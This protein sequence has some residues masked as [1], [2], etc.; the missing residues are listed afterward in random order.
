MPSPRRPAE[1]EYYATML[2]SRGLATNGQK[3]ERAIVDLNGKDLPETFVVLRELGGHVL[4]LDPHSLTLA[5][6]DP[7][8]FNLAESIA[9]SMGIGESTRRG[10]V[11]LIRC[12]S[13]DDL[14]LL[15][16]LLADWVG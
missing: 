3:A 1:I 16:L 13:V 2:D 15:G 4:E 12:A 10:G 11:L 9:D 6:L 14:E 8:K 5:V 7:K